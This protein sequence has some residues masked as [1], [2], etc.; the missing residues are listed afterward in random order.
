MFPASSTIENT[1]HRRR[2]VFAKST[3]VQRELH[4]NEALK[5]VRVIE[6]NELELDRFKVSLS[7]FYREFGSAV[8]NSGSESTTAH[9][10]LSMPLS[11]QKP[12]SSSK[13]FI[14]GING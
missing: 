10:L 9:S 3:L 7:N 13:D 8:Q 14:H 12:G 4:R 6:A 5:R 2:F 1:F 11:I